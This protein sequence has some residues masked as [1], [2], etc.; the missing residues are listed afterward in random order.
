MKWDQ[1]WT[2]LWR[3]SLEPDEIQSIEAWLDD[4]FPSRGSD[5]GWTGHELCNAL[6]DIAERARAKG[7]RSYPPEGPQIKSAIIRLRYQARDDSSEAFEGEDCGLCEG[8]A[9]LEMYPDEPDDIALDAVATDRKVVVPC[10]CSNGD[11]WM[12]TCRE[13]KSLSPGAIDVVQD[14]REKAKRQSVALTRQ[15][16]RLSRT[17]RE[18]GGF[19][20]S[21]MAKEIGNRWACK[22]ERERATA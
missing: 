21:E 4:Q 7:K 10:L 18:Q 12:R 5:P 22:P 14:L 11:R 3:R 19:S 1:L 6:N 15:A 2:V 8:S 16:E 20:V 9:W 17:I 13:Y